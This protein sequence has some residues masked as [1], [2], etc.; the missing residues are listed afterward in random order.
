MSP[1]RK[2]MIEDLVVRNYS[3]K[4]IDQ[5]VRVVRQIAEFYQKSPADLT[6]E[7]IRD[8]QVY[9]RQEK[10]VSWE[11]GNQTVCALRFLYR[12]TLGR[13][14]AVVERIAYGRRTTT[15][16]LAAPQK[17]SP[18]VAAPVGSGRRDSHP[19][20]ALSGSPWVFLVGRPT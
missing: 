8:Y 1:L 14:D 20:R 15:T 12:V 7:E 6:Q 17:S 18:H 4:T 5:Y 10:K 2:R 3:E 19:W 16:R 11:V 9:L 13:E